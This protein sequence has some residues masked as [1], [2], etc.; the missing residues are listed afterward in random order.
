MAYSSEADFSSPFEYTSITSPAYKIWRTWMKL[1]RIMC[2]LTLVA[3]FSLAIGSVQAQSHSYETAG[4]ITF[5]LQTGH[6][7]VHAS[8]E[9]TK[10]LDELMVEG[11]VYSYD[12]GGTI[13]LD[14]YAKNTSSRVTSCVHCFPGSAKFAEAF[15]HVAT[16]DT[17]LNNSLMAECDFYYGSGTVN[18][19][20]YCKRLEAEFIPFYL[21]GSQRTNNSASEFLLQSLND[22][23]EST[24][25]YRSLQTLP[26][27]APHLPSCTPIEQA[28][29]GIEVQPGIVNGKNFIYKCGSSM[30]AVLSVLDN[31]HSKRRQ[32]IPLGRAKHLIN[33]NPAS[34]ALKPNGPGARAAASWN[35]MYDYSLALYSTDPLSEEKIVHLLSFIK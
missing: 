35:G 11:T 10:D 34:I 1:S 15:Y 28:P 29:M 9:G 8:I 21:K 24:T 26:S 33:G 31:G 4:G 18:D 5:S 32:K 25:N 17:D 20:G 2:V 30:S 23:L 14:L 16:S 13:F 6:A 27:R 3:I 7:Y 12:T 19:G 22:A